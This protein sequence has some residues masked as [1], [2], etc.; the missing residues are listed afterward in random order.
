MLTSEG[1]CRHETPIIT[2]PHAPAT[3]HDHFCLWLK[4]TCPQNTSKLILTHMSFPHGLRTRTIPR[5][6]YFHVDVQRYR[7]LKSEKRTCMFGQ[8]T[9]FGNSWKKVRFGSL[10]I[11]QTRFRNEIQCDGHTS[12]LEENGTELQSSCSIIS[13]EV[14]NPYFVQPVHWTEDT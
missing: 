8:C 2:P 10:V 4:M 14:V 7:M 1:R 3:D 13:V 12:S 9:N 5:E 11:P 6:K